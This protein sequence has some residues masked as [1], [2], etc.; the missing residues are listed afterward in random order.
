M[1]YGYAAALSDSPDSGDTAPPFQSTIVSDV[2]V[3][4]RRTNDEYGDPWIVVRIDAW[5]S[6]AA[7]W[8]A[9]DMM[10][11]SQIPFFLR[12]P[13]PLSNVND[14]RRLLTYYSKME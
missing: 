2:S 12:L 13:R 11:R 1:R 8:G 5:F 6:K 14:S 4:F 9:F 10:G 7:V 3:R